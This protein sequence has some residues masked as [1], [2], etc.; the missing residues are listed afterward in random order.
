MPSCAQH[1]T[2]DTD[3][4]CA[5]C[6]RPHCDACLV[7]FLGQWHCGY[8]RD[9]KLLAMQGPLTDDAPLAGTGTVDI[10]RWLEFGWQMVSRD[11]ATWM[12]ATLL[13]GV[14]GAFSCGICAPALACGLY[15]M[16]FR[17]MTYGRV[18]IGNVF[19]GF[20]RFLW[21]LLLGLLIGISSYALVFLVSLPLELLTAKDESL[22]AVA[23]L[24]S[25]GWSFIVQIALTGF[26]L[27]AMPHVA[28]RNAPPIDALAASFAV[29]RRNIPMFLL[30]GFVFNLISGLGICACIVGVLLTMPWIV[31]ATAKAYA[32]HFGIR[33]WEA[34]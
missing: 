8:C 17:S 28:A 9:Q 13:M 22:N 23:G 33:G 21:A 6:G 15:M 10:S 11:V 25:Q 27:F 31:A 34:V 20:R 24:V 2:V 1:P 30:C 3:R 32:D 5:T 29:V 14:L 12:V 7:E 4:A 19:D 18:E 26:T 16:A